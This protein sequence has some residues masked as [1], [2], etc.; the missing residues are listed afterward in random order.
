[1]HASLLDD[2]SYQ[3]EIFTQNEAL[4]G[5]HEVKVSAVDLETGLEYGTKVISLFI[6]PD[7]RREGVT[8]DESLDTNIRIEK[9]A[10]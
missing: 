5:P 1:M 9:P 3:I 7:C 4:L 10:D 8:Y 6:A 2:D